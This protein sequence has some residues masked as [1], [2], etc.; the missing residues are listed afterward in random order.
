MHHYT[1]R[2]EGAERQIEKK[3][4]GEMRAESSTVK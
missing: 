4:G 2:Q 1:P 3:G